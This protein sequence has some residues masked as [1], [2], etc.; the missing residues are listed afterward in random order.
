MLQ[1][2]VLG[3]TD[4]CLCLD[5]SLGFIPQQQRLP[6]HGNFRLLQFRFL[7]DAYRIKFKSVK[8]SY[9][10]QPALLLSPQLPLPSLGLGNDSGFVW[11]AHLCVSQNDSFSIRL[12]LTSWLVST[13]VVLTYALHMSLSATDWLLNIPHP[14]ACKIK[15]VLFSVRGVRALTGKA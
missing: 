11:V 13:Q 10:T 14:Y 2:I 8:T 7:S 12:F 4:N 9:K 15:K 6:Y 1:D 5:S 3:R